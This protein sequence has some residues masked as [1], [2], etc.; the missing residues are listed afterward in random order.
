MADF[1]DLP[2]LQEGYMDNIRQGDISGLF[3]NVLQTIRDESGVDDYVRFIK[4]LNQGNFGSAAKSLGTGLFETL[5]AATTFGGKSLLTGAARKGAPSFLSK[6]PLINRAPGL[7]SSTVPESRLAKY[8]VPLSVDE[9]NLARAGRIGQRIQPGKL[10]KAQKAARSNMTLDQQLEQAIANDSII[11]RGLKRRLLTGVDADQ[12]FTPAAQYYA[13]E[14][15][16][17]GLPFLR[18]NVPGAKGT[19]EPLGGVGKRF[20]GMGGYRTPR[21]NFGYGRGGI[22]GS[23]ARGV[24][25]F[26]GA[27]P[28]NAPQFKFMQ[29]RI[30]RATPY[31]T[32]LGIKSGFS[33]I[34]ILGGDALSTLLDGL[35]TGDLKLEELPPA[36]QRDLA[37][38]INDSL[39]PGKPVEY[40]QNLQIGR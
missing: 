35:L 23:V 20:F 21:S 13:K 38:V 34:G 1:W 28:V 10:S 29:N 37:A 32:Q 17:K 6:I 40:Y 26:T 27:L 14:G 31:L 2:R 3:G 7:L 30:G 22:V 24:G 16:E 5:G 11:R 9:Q 36:I 25:Q 18:V 19:M 15:V 8:L 39:E 4:H 12:T 33:P